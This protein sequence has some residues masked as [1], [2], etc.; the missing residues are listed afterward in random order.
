METDIPPGIVHV[1]RV[2]LDDHSA[3]GELRP[4]LSDDECARADRLFTAE[5][6]ARYT[7]AHGWKRRILS[8]YSR[9][10]PAA[11]RFSASP[12]GKPALID[13]PD[14]HFNLSHSGQLAL[15]AV[16]AGAAVGVDVE[17]QKASI[18]HLDIAERF[19][20]AAE[21]EVLRGL[22]A[23]PE[24]MTSA[25]FAA[26]TRKEAYVKARGD[27][28][29]QGLQHFDVALAPGSLARL[30]ADRMHT[31]APSRWSMAA[32][33]ID[34]GYTAAVVHDGPLRDV[35]LFELSDYML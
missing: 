9:T 10:A 12:A 24:Q 6:R 35:V 14:V 19:F 32:V 29:S 13:A 1:W 17:Q 4:L 22:S 7:L 25:F 31:D 20:S 18:R 30:L 28:I 16:A 21:C 3:A 11:L 27:T 5:L 8:R 34:A 23:D 15:V 26:W 2:P 33:A